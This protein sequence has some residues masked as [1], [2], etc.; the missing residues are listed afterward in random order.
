MG[1][2]IT[3]SGEFNIDQA[4]REKADNKEKINTDYSF[5]IPFQPNKKLFIKILKE[6]F[7]IS[8]IF[9]KTC[10]LWGY[11]STERKRIK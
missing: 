11:V 4:N 9:K 7:G 8:T 6:P 10:K 5:H 1:T 2:H 3:W